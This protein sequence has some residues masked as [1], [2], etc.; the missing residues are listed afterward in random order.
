MRTDVEIARDISD[1]LPNDGLD[2]PYRFAEGTI[3]EAYCWSLLAGNG[4]HP[5]EEAN[6]HNAEKLK[7]ELE[8]YLRDPCRTD[9]YY[10]HI[11]KTIT[12]IILSACENRTLLT[13]SHGHIGIGPPAAK[14]G[15]EIIVLLGCRQ[16]LVVRKVAGG[17]QL[18][19]ECYIHGLQHGEAILG[20]LPDGW[21]RKFESGDLVATFQNERTGETTKVDPRLKRF[22]RNS[23]SLR[24]WWRGTVPYYGLLRAK[25]LN[26]HGVDIIDFD[27]I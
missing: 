8:T 26:R 18:I 25:R 12:P 21:R 4:T 6:V 14:T 11:F 16:P 22:G 9:P 23:Q 3:F 5:G 19:G 15:D 17:Y 20:A 24:L 13:S 27:L 2:G 7:S 10:L 1:M